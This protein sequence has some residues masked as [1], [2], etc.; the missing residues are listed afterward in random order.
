MYGDLSQF[1]SFT[2][3]QS[4][5]GEMIP[6]PCA[7]RGALLAAVSISQPHFRKKTAW[8][9]KNVSHHPI[10]SE[11]YPAQIL[12]SKPK[13]P[14]Y[15]PRILANNARGTRCA[16]MISTKRTPWNPD[17]RTRNQAPCSPLLR[18]NPPPPLRHSSPIPASPRPPSDK[19]WLIDQKGESH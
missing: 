19:K 2:R 17:R 6:P 12:M 7:Q 9:Y 5:K 4:P 11:V 3:A 16:S 15:L 18:S 1:E 8:M 13:P 14:S 10:L